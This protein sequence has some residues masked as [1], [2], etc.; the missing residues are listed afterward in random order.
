MGIYLAVI[1]FTGIYAIWKTD[2]IRHRM[3]MERYEEEHREFVRN[4]ERRFARL[5]ERE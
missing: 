4:M 5:A 3:N 2:R 1:S